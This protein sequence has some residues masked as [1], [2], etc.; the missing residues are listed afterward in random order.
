MSRVLFVAALLLSVSAFVTS[1]SQLA[2]AQTASTQVVFSGT[3]SGVFNTKTTH[4]GFWIW[5]EGASSNPY[6]GAC[7]GAMYFYALGI[8]RPV[9]GVV[10]GTK[11]EFVMNVHSP[12]TTPAVKCTLNNV[13]PITSGPTNTVNVACSAPSGSG[14][15]TSAVVVVTGP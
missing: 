11:P 1:V 9:T 15:S 5:C 3:G 6:V 10:T 14:A 7:N 12:G 4:F 8:T 2:P 13:A